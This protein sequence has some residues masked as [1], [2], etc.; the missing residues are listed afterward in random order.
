MIPEQQLIASERKPLPMRT[1]W[2]QENHRAEKSSQSFCKGNFWWG[3]RW[4]LLLKTTT[5]QSISIVPFH[6]VTTLSKNRTSPF[7]ELLWLYSS[8]SDYRN[9][10]TIHR[11]FPFC[12]YPFLKV[13][14]KGI[15]WSNGRVC[16]SDDSDDQNLSGLLIIIFENRHQILELE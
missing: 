10:I 6:S 2:N 14:L 16:I 7:F 4:K 11:T 12:E 1:P 3:Y 15:G 8:P 9:P 5:F 13:V